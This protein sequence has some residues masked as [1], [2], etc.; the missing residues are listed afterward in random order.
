MIKQILF[1]LTLS[2]VTLFTTLTA[3][4][5]C[6]YA[7]SV[8]V[9][10]ANCYNSTLVTLT[11]EEKEGVAI[12]SLLPNLSLIRCHY[13]RL[14]EEAISYS[15]IPTFLLNDGDYEVGISAVYRTFTGG[16]TEY[17]LVDAIDTLHLHSD[18]T[19]PSM[20]AILH[21]AKQNNEYGMRPA[22]GCLNTGRC[23]LRIQG[24]SFPYRIQVIDPNSNDTLK[25]ILFNEPQY[26]GN[27]PLQYDYHEYY[28]ID[29]LP[30]GDY[31]FLLTD[32]C[33]YS[34]SASNQH[35]GSVI[36]L[37]IAS[38]EHY[39]SKCHESYHN[40]FRIKA[41]MKFPYQYYYDLIKARMLY[42]TSFSNGDSSHYKPLPIPE[43][44]TSG[45]YSVDLWD[46]AYSATRYCE[47]L[48]EQIVMLKMQDCDDSKAI[49][50][51]SL[52]ELDKKKYTTYLQNSVI[53]LDTLSY[54]VDACGTI[55]YTT[56]EVSGTSYIM[57]GF[58]QGRLE[59][60]L[61]QSASGSQLR[62][63]F[64]T[65]PITW[66][67][68]DAES[69]SLIAEG[70]TADPTKGFALSKEVVSNF[71]G[72]PHDAPIQ[73]RI[74]TKM[75][76]AKGCILL[77]T[78]ALF[79][80]QW[81]ERTLNNQRL[82]V[83]F[84]SYGGSYFNNSCCYKSKQKLIVNLKYN[85]AYE[86]D[87][88]V[89]SLIESPEL[90][91][92]RFHVVFYPAE[93]RYVIHKEDSNDYSIEINS[94][95]TSI[96]ISDYC[97]PRGKYRYRL[98]TPCQSQEINFSFSN[99]R[100]R[101]AIVSRLPKFNI[102]QE[103]NEMQ[104]TP[105][106]GQ[107][108]EI[109]YAKGQ[110]S[111]PSNITE[112]NDNI[113]FQVI[114]GPQGGYTEDIIAK[115][116]TLH[117]SI[118]GD[119]TI[120]MFLSPYTGCDIEHYDTTISF[121]YQQV[122]FK[123]ATA[124][125]CDSSSTTGNVHVRGF[126]GKEP[127]HY[128]LYNAPNLG[129][130]NLG[131]N[132]TGDFY[133]L[134][135]HAGEILSCKIQ[136][137]CGNAFHI[138]FDVVEL[139]K[140]EKAWFESGERSI[141]SCE[142]G[143]LHI[144]TLQLSDEINYLWRG[145]DGYESHSANPVI[146]LERGAS[147]GYYHLTLLNTSCGR[148]VR[149]SVWVDVLPAPNITMGGDSL[150]CPGTEVD[151]TFTPTGIGKI[152][153]SISEECMGEMRHYSFVD[154]N[155]Q[156]Q[157][158]RIPI[159]AHTTIRVPI[160][161]D[162]LCPF[163]HIND[164][165]VIRVK[166]SP[167]NLT[168]YHTLGDTLCAESTA[169]LQARANSDN[170]YIL[171][172]Y[173]SPLLDSCLR[174][175]TLAPLS[176]ST[177]LIEG[178]AQDT[179]LYLHAHTLAECPHH[180]MTIQRALPMRESTEDLM[181]GERIHWYDSGGS[182]QLYPQGESI[183][184]C[185]RAQPQTSLSVDFHT[186]K[187]HPNDILYIFNSVTPRADS[188]LTTLSGDLSAHLPSTITSPNGILSFMFTANRGNEEGWM[189]TLSAKAVIGK[190]EATVKRINVELH[191][192]LPTCPIIGDSVQLSA[193]LTSANDMEHC[194]RWYRQ[195]VNSHEWALVDS[196]IAEDSSTLR[197]MI[198]DSTHSFHLEVENLENRCRHTAHSSILKIGKPKLT[199][200]SSINVTGCDTLLPMLIS[201]TNSTCYRAD[202][203]YLSVKIPDPL[204][205][206]DIAD[207]LLFIPTLEG[208]SS[209]DTTLTL[210]YNSMTMS[211]LHRDVKVEIIRCTQEDADST[212]Q[213]G[214]WDGT[215]LP[216]QA[217][218]NI[219]PV[220]LPPRI[221]HLDAIIS[222]EDS[223]SL[224]R[225]HL[226]EIDIAA[227]L[228]YPQYYQWLSD[229]NG[230]TIFSTDT[231]Y[232]AGEVLILRNITQDTT[233]FL[234]TL[235]DS[236]C[237]LD[238]QTI[239]ITFSIKPPQHDTTYLS[240][241]QSQQ[242]LNHTPF[243][244]LD[245]SRHGIYTYDTL[246][247]DSVGCD[248]IETLILEVLPP[249]ITILTDSACNSYSW[250]DSVYHTSGTFYT[251]LTDALGRD[252]VLQLELTIFE[253][254]ETEFYD[255]ACDAYHWEDSTYYIGGTHTQHFVTNSGCDSI[256]HL[257]LTLHHSQHR[258][259]YDTVCQQNIPYHHPLFNDI[260]ISTSGEKLAD[261]TLQT[262]KGC[263]STIL[264]RLFVKPT[265]SFEEMSDT[266]FCNGKELTIVPQSDSYSG[267]DYS[268]MLQHGDA[269]LLISHAVGS[270][271]DTMRLSLDNNSTEKATAIFRIDATYQHCPSP[272]FSLSI[273]VLPSI[274]ITFGHYDTTL[275][276]PYGSCKMA[277]D[278]N[279]LNQI[280]AAHELEH[281]DSITNNVGSL[282][283]LGEG[284]HTI[285]W[286]L[287]D[288]CG[289]SREFHQEVTIVAPPCPDAIDYEGNRYPSVRIDCNCWTTKNLDSRY[290]RDGSP[291]E[292]HYI[293]LS[294]NF[295]D[296][297]YNRDTFGRL[298]GFEAIRGEEDT[299]WRLN[300]DKICPI[301]WRLPTEA[302]YLAIKH[303][304]DGLRS[305]LFWIDGGGNNATGF[306][307]LPGGFY[308]GSTDR[309]EQILCRA[310]YWALP[311]EITRTT[312][313]ECS[314][315]YHCRSI[316]LEEVKHHNGY[317]VRCIKVQE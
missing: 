9:D 218:E 6:P 297:N 209:Y 93:D 270:A 131:E 103:C 28:S 124:Y 123:Y 127:Y 192:Q 286:Q 43:S 98:Q 49:Y 165:I 181:A 172:W 10:H 174:S 134:L 225:N 97:I 243:S 185:F 13:R 92:Y 59:C 237:G 135:L 241:A 264:L 308:N 188:L 304:E 244:T 55:S 183:V 301:G 19:I 42:R 279:W 63:C 287:T 283:A 220:I 96:T 30:A 266:L 61:S 58:T 41:T 23:Q 37:D 25:T 147:S 16:S 29:S 252:S 75:Q 52:E 107:F 100:Y 217:D 258:T 230:L 77:D 128:T 229:S 294:E 57:L 130:N 7:L 251:T 105:T 289:N 161:E 232:G 263:D 239:P 193:T 156:T 145:P 108:R 119:Y 199:L 298:Y 249:P 102:A 35:L 86:M 150:V 80:Y 198:T 274:S 200:A 160:I 12:D 201:V 144:Y 142:G 26:S 187:T 247:V 254:Y 70:T 276:L 155:R 163:Y 18:Y 280:K 302:E 67:Y 271:V 267:I 139:N 39:N 89:V 36:G 154:T 180:A 291:I 133:N 138:N 66:R 210:F 14:E 261:T 162:A 24:G 317:S 189:A 269:A 242:I 257:H 136:D 191:E 259:I 231:L 313:Y 104:I 310:F 148:P 76:D 197:S 64:Y 215:R 167:K 228:P 71:F 109:E 260:D 32:G 250:H 33:N 256:V 248:L 2:F 236:I 141:H 1:A 245:I 121:Q 47:L 288:T 272:P 216:L 306:N 114:A 170:N 205:H 262:I 234:R 8:S 179:T 177:F 182:S 44:Y 235:S 122:D 246:L 99:E 312:L 253:Q 17:I 196:V 186:F 278:T 159:Y 171:N 112:I 60:N 178:L 307:S 90:N 115:H 72:L 40:I 149:D 50:H 164:S 268:W 168:T 56:R 113:L 27:D 21:I 285:K 5:T 169:T 11:M 290:Y 34:V 311:D 62:N 265:L 284:S 117:F 219:V 140:T 85:N 38:I 202:S 65:T 316:T 48:G 106:E 277:L 126:G 120:R 84:S 31:T 273:V 212:T 175:D 158:L 88:I 233:L 4:T 166:S 78:I 79:H 54:S 129:G 300:S 213:Y 315:A 222:V 194:F 15:H 240:V 224:C 151:L 292:N 208:N 3:Q 238:A 293:Y 91:Y 73:K 20:A 275:T 94:T 118:P 207:S 176:M 226:V 206:R 221:L 305:S 143:S 204:H 153:Y 53:Q 146:A 95:Q 184:Q 303:Y 45:S 152:E 101:T 190:V 214:D 203:I 51:F 46:T 110:G 82:G 314:I 195:K 22:L 227:A 309:F 137:A 211:T 116:E 125:I 68:F 223:F 281:I 296:T 87:S 111:L 173:D 255:T 74:R 295:P 69:D 299:L 83:S 282:G 157:H 132:T 81:Q